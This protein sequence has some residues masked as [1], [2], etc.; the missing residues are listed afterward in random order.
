MFPNITHALISRQNLIKNLM[1][2]TSSSRNA[3]A[4]P[5]YGSFFLCVACKNGKTIFFSYKL[6]AEHE[7]FFETSAFKR[8]CFSCI[9][10]IAWRIKAMQQLSTAWLGCLCS[11]FNDLNN[12]FLRSAFFFPRSRACRSKCVKRM[13]YIYTTR[14]TSTPFS[15]FFCLAWE[16]EIY[17][18]SK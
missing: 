12:H 11:F 7:I 4:A 18:S 10:L 5:I 17:F 8:I 13:D 3:N 16:N 14:T 6:V 9:S 15:F 2:S 1:H